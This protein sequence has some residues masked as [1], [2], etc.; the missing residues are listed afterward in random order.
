MMKDWTDGLRPDGED[1]ETFRKYARRNGIEQINNKTNTDEGICPP[2]SFRWEVCC[3]VLL[4]CYSTIQTW[5][6]ILSGILE[7]NISLQGEWFLNI[8]LNELS[9]IEIK[10]ILDDY[11]IYNTHANIAL[12]SG[13]NSESLQRN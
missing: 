9:L 13:D 6:Y 4:N 12:N 5:W 3:W 1:A 2:M 10:I 11:N 7:S 8:I